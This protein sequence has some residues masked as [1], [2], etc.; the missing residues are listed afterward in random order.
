[1]CHKKFNFFLSFFTLTLGLFIYFALRPEHLIMFEW[2]Q[3]LGLDNFVE[4]IR[5]LTKE[6][7]LSDFVIYNLPYALWSFSFVNF[8]IVIWD[9]N[10]STNLKYYFLLLILLIT[11]PEFLQYFKLINGTFDVYDLLTNLLFILCS[12][13]LNYNKIK[14]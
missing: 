12:I 3:F 2:V 13:I 6:L 8:L 4:Y 10:F 1:M 11:L 7:K 9:Y 14:F 5:L